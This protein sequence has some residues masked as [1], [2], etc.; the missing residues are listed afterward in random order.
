MLISSR[1]NHQLKLAR[2][3]REGREPSLLFIEGQ[4]LVH[5]Y[6]E[7]DLKLKTL[8][9]LPA[10]KQR[11]A[12]IISRAH[13][14][15]CTAFETDEKVFATLGDTVTSQGI[16]VIAE[17]PVWTLAQ[18]LHH[19]RGHTSF[20]V[21]LDGVQDPGNLGTVVRTAE[22]AG[23]GGVVALPGCTD[24]FAPKTL[25]AAMGSAFRL[26]VI[27]GISLDFVIAQCHEQK[28][29]LVGTAAHAALDN[30]ELDWRVPTLVFFGSEASGLTP[31]VLAR[32]NSMVRI[33]LQRPV[34]SLNVAAA[35]AIILFEA[36]RQRGYLSAAE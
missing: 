14:R 21:V 16:I 17:R 13:E 19:R 8:L 9:Y 31:D 36:A 1:A 7:T 35:A 6:L 3:A 34:E 11:L 29:N 10:A 12:Q 32:C 15:G 2:R 26:P 25:R 28:S 18:A 30:T 20:V 4:R 27:T 22:A 33:P 24:P 23:A 5:E